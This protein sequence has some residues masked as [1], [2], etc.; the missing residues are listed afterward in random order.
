MEQTTKNKTIALIRSEKTWLL[1]I[2]FIIFATFISI[3]QS[4]LSQQSSAV[5]P[6]NRGLSLRARG[7]LRPD[8]VKGYM[9]FGFISRVFNVPSDF[10]KKE[11]SVNDSRYPKI[12]IDEYAEKNGIPTTQ[13][14]SEVIA[15]LLRFQKNASSTPAGGTQ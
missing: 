14:Q 1:V 2:I 5:K 7:K 8:Q 4:V 10:L 6:S 9:T 11:L 13:L 3:L 15:I 12:S